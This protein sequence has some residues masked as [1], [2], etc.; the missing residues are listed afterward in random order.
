MEFLTRRLPEPI[1]GDS[2]VIPFQL[3]HGHMPGLWRR[4][5]R[6]ARLL[7]LIVLGAAGCGAGTPGEGV[8]AAPAEAR[9]VL[10]LVSVV[11]ERGL[12]L[13]LGAM[14]EMGGIEFLR[15]FRRYA[16]TAQ[17]PVIVLTAK[18]LTEEDTSELKGA[19]TRVL[20]EGDASGD[21]IL[22]EIRRQLVRAQPAAAGG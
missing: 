2:R 3:D 19:V 13:V 1:L 21:D 9:L 6:V 4:S 5:H 7:T 20:Q 12:C 14:P 17:T 18:D 11:D 16:G 15:H 10:T 22:G 8:E